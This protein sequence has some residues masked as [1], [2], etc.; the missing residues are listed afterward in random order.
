MNDPTHYPMGKTLTGIR[1]LAGWTPED[2]AAYL[3][4]PLPRLLAFEACTLS[5][6]YLV[7]QYG[8]MARSGAVAQPEGRGGGAKCLR[9]S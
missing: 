7:N 6:Q 4:V 1:K 9:A 8:K 3:K 2:L 5:D